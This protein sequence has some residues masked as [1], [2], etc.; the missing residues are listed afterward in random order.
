MIYRKD[1]DDPRPLELVNKT[2][3]FNLNGLRITETAWRER[4]NRPETVLQVVNYSDKFGPLGKIGVLLGSQEGDTVTVDAWVLSC[5]AFSRRIEFQC[6][7]QLFAREGVR[8]VRF[9]F[10]ATP[11]NGP[12]Q[13]FLGHFFQGPLEPGLELTAAGFEA[14]APKLYHRVNSEN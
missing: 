8:R 11:K 9:S 7:S 3:Q 5:R 1:A 14:K 2:N 4:L 13:S 10:L 6:L 12:L